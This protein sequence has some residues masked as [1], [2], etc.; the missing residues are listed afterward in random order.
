MEG[1]NQYIELKDLDA[2][3]FAR[4][5]S[6]FSWIIF[7]RLD[8]ENKKVMGDQ[9]IRS[10]DSVG[11]NIAEGYGRYHYLDKNKFYF[12]ARGSLL[13]SRHWGGLM[14]ERQLITKEEFDIMVDYYIKISTKINRLIY[15]QA[16]LN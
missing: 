1:K 7:K 9:F 16:N 4:Q 15:I 2:Y 13:E 5:Y 10:V 14:L 3:I 12:N 11:A 8:W 6:N